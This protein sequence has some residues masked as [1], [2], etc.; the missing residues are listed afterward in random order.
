MERPPLPVGTFGKI[1]IRVL[2]KG[3]VEAGPGVFS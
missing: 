3:R 1:H 2:G